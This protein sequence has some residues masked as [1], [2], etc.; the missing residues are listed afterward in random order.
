M[1]HYCLRD[2]TVSETLL[3][4]RLY[5]LRDSRRY[6]VNFWKTDSRYIT[7]FRYG[8]LS[9]I[10]LIKHCHIL[11]KLL[12]NRQ[13]LLTLSGAISQSLVSYGLQWLSQCLQAMLGAA[14][15]LSLTIAARAVSESP[16]CCYKARLTLAAMANSVS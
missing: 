10:E 5:C 9:P 4:Q 12:E 2:T 15:T 3:S 16:G 7:I 1:R 6:Y 13:A 8:D 14:N 11:C